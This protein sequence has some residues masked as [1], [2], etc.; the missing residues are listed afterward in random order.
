MGRTQTFVNLETASEICKDFPDKHNALKNGFKTIKVSSAYFQ[1][2]IGAFQ[3]LFSSC[4]FSLLI[5]MVVQMSRIFH[6]KKRQEELE[7]K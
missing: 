1:T 3:K 7:G 2:E 5:L 4:Y 6:N